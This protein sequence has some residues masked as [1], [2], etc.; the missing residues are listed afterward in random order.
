MRLT[1]GPISLAWVAIFFTFCAQSSR[2]LAVRF[3]STPSMKRKIAS[4]AIS[5]AITTTVKTIRVISHPFQSGS[6]KLGHG[7][8]DPVG[9]PAVDHHGTRP[10]VPPVGPPLWSQRTT[11]PR[12][13]S[14]QPWPETTCRTTSAATPSATVITQACLDA[15]RCGHSSHYNSQMRIFHAISSAT[16]RKEI[17][18][19]G[20]PRWAVATCWQNLAVGDVLFLGCPADRRLIRLRQ[21][22]GP[23]PVG[24]QVPSAPTLPSSTPELSNTSRPAPVSSSGA[25]ERT[26]G[27][28]AGRH[29]CGR[30]TR[31]R[32]GGCWD[33]PRAVGVDDRCQARRG[34]DS[35]IRWCGFLVTTSHALPE[36]NKSR[37]GR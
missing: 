3:S 1:P 37:I 28:D 29:S 10:R 36:E 35:R 34:G 7:Q 26:G 20:L 14:G 31:A 23:A 17:G 13:R 2:L 27:G 32:R 15:S 16:A 25:L 5:A 6:R 11:G 21:E 12:R 30:G 24:R 33:S 4:T 19:D 18:P 8:L 22:G 9:C